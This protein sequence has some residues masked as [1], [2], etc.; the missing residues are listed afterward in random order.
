MVHIMGAKSA[1][2]MWKQL[3]LVKEARGRLGILSYQCSLYC[4][5]AD[6]STNIV[7]HDHA[8]ATARAASLD[9]QP[10]I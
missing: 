5:I 10:C 4:T 6:E 2:E 3:T 8:S 1:E 9:E 7:A